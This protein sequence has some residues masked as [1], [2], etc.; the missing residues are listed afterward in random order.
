MIRATV[1]RPIRAIEP[2]GDDRRLTFC[3][4]RKARAS[5]PSPEIPQARCPYH[6]PTTTGNPNTELGTALMKRL[7]RGSLIAV[8][9][10]QPIQIGGA[11]DLLDDRRHF[12][13]PEL[14]PSVF[15]PALEQDQLAQ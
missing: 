15:H 12:T 11:E 14:A 2:A 8:D 4:R 1:A 7:D 13:Q 10:E 6:I 9:A 5:G 3:P